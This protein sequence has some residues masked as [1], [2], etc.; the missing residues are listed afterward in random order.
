M[1][2]L[3]DFGNQDAAIS[4]AHDLMWEGYTV[5]VTMVLNQE[6]P[7]RF[8]IWGTD[9]PVLMTGSAARNIGTGAQRSTGE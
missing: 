3:G 6:Y 8:I 2:K 7:K 9:A 5:V 1:K 4:R